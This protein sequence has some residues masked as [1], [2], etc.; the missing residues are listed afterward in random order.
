MNQMT[1]E[2]A[3]KARAA[4]TDHAGSTLKDVRDQ[5]AALPASTQRR[6]TLSALDAVQKLFKRD[7]ATVQTNWRALRQ[8]F[9]GRNAAQLGVSEK[10]YAN[11]R[12][13]IVRAVKGHGPASP[14]MA[15]RMPLAPAWTALLETV[16]L[17]RYGQALSRLARF[18][19]VLRI[20]PHH[21][22]KE[23]LL[24][25]HDAMTAEE[26][27]KDPRRILKHTVAHWNMCQKR[28]PEWPDYKLA[29]PFPSNRFMLDLQE[30][31]SSFQEDV[32]KWRRRVL[33][34]DILDEDGPDVALRPITVDGEE[35]LLRRF[36]SALINTGHKKLEEITS[37]AVLVEI[38]QLK[39]GIRF[40]LKR[41]GGNPTGYVRKFA[42][43]LLSVARHHVKL[44]EK[45][46]AAIRKVVVKLGKREVGMT[47]RNRERL[48]QFDDHENVVK[49]LTSPQMER[50]RGLKITNLY[51]RAK[52]FERALSAAILIYASVRMQNLRTIQI[53]KNI[54]YSRGVCILSFDKTEMKNGRPL[55]LELPEGVANLLQEFVRNHRPILPGADGPYL[56]P[57]RDGGPRSHN[58]M[59][60]DFEGAV[61]KHT[62]LKVNP[63]L[64]RHA[65][66]MLA[67]NQDPAN[68][69]MVA[70][71]LGHSGIQ[72]A[73]DFYLG[74]ESRPSSRVMNTI[75]E[76]V[77]KLPSK[78]KRKR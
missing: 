6:D 18:C 74:N 37:L 66:A 67:I 78:S 14:F 60:Q 1:P 39:Q 15:K 17:R 32:A 47:P 5:V 58:T 16:P 52:A 69:P 8:L 28:V 23:T 40:F 50:N 44:P 31:P 65:T 30:F 41:A 46:I 20:S 42:W 9:Q 73:R 43:L 51:R 54:R 61:L 33:K 71:R 49:L 57:G 59:R 25:F 7:L 19:S 27:I 4:F 64:M 77:I 76:E 12:S 26:V 45:E 11:I 53:E 3:A 63:H 70:Q 36:A 13:D 62:G 21:I 29:S 75:L 2:F 56:F 68:L 35:K 34:A 10:R 24:A 22:T 38:D 48:S 55:E 72:T